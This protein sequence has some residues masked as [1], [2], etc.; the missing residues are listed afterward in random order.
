MHLK[1]EE[2]IIQ[3][4]HLAT[5]PGV[6]VDPYCYFLDSKVRQIKLRMLFN[7]EFLINSKNITNNKLNSMV[8][9]LD[10]ITNFEAI[11]SRHIYLAKRHLREKI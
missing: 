2:T 4:H 6:I 8:T 7:C 1:Y 5:P 11:C 3:N 10:V 9:L